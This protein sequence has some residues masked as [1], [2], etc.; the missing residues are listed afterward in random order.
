MPRVGGKL[1]LS[2]RLKK[3]VQLYYF[4]PAFFPLN[5]A[6]W[7]QS[8]EHNE[9]VDR[10]APQVFGVFRCETAK[11]IQSSSPG[12]RVYNRYSEVGL[13][14]AREEGCFRT[15]DVTSVD[16]R[17]KGG[18]THLTNPLAIMSSIHGE[19][20]LDPICFVAGAA[21]LGSTCEQWDRSEAQVEDACT[22]PGSMSLS[23]KNFFN[24]TAVLGTMYTTY[25]PSIFVPARASLYLKNK[26]TGKVTADEK[27]AR[28]TTYPT[29]P[30]A[31]AESRKCSDNVVSK[32]AQHSTSVRTDDQQTRRRPFITV[33]IS[34]SLFHHAL[35]DFH[36]QQ[37]VSDR[38]Q[39][40]VGGCAVCSGQP[41]RQLCPPA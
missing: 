18:V 6:R 33:P 5:T 12:Q 8:A 39:R 38:Q 10:R 13:S 35:T 30:V 20:A 36:Q 3:Q 11:V 9:F 15:D 25:K 32:A 17:N 16:G 7:S 41:W 14:R 37:G 22:V 29:Q 31:A 34:P 4:T 40:Y 1:S 19:T 21:K 2:A 26:L 28:R 24:R 23:K 27:Q